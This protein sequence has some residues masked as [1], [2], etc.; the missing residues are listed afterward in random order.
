MT[1]WH[2]KTPVLFLCLLAAALLASCDCGDDDDDN[3]AGDDDDDDA[4]DDD[5]NDDGDDDDTDVPSDCPAG[6]IPDLPETR[7]GATAAVIDNTI[8]VLGGMN[9]VGDVLGTVLVYQRGDLFWSTEATQDTPRYNMASVTFENMI[10][11]MGGTSETDIATTDF[12]GYN[13]T[14]QSFHGTGTLPEAGTR[15]GSG[16]IGDYL[17]LFG[18]FNGAPMNTLW[19][20]YFLG[21][22]WEPLPLLTAPDRDRFGGA[23]LG[24]YL[25]VVGGQTIPDHQY[26]NL[27]RYDP[28][29]LIWGT[30]PSMSHARADLAAVAVDP[31]LFVLGGWSLTQG[32]HNDVEAYFPDAN[33]WVELD[34]LQMPRR[35]AGAAACDQYIYLVG[36]MDNDGNCLTSVEVYDT[37]WF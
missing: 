25:Y 33:Q 19:R 27:D 7:Y 34:A 2:A 20:Y 28:S 14:T 35:G 9:S 18:G 12:E 24:D 31:Y 36:G 4:T 16:L 21:A 11:L 23:A 6:P 13:T 5:D 1:A 10:Y 37:N 26:D 22:A 30:G 15:Y 32:C 3:D 29:N 17:Y 8:Y